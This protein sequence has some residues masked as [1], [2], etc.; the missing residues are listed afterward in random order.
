[1]EDL[2]R[3]IKDSLKYHKLLEGNVSR[4][5]TPITTVLNRVTIR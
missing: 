1:V 5:F 3:R 2:E 4:A